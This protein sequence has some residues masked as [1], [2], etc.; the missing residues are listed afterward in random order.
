MKRDFGPGGWVRS[1][2]CGRAAGGQLVVVERLLPFGLRK[3]H[4][5]L[6]ARR[7]IAVEHASD[8]MAGFGAGKP[9]LKD[10]LRMLRRR[11]QH[12]GAPGEDKQDYRLADTRRSARAA[13]ADCR[14][15]RDGRVSRLRRSSNSIR[16]APSRRHRPVA[17]LC[18]AAAKPASE[19]ERISVPCA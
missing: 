9:H 15:D 3:A 10:G 16:R 17:R 2:V 1:A 4:R 6:A 5:Q 13:A 12:Q 7:D 11:C 8:G 14:A 18:S 19:S